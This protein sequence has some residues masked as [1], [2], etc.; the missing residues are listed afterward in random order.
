MKDQENSK[1]DFDKEFSMITN[2]PDDPR[3]SKR[4]GY[5]TA[6]PSE[7][8]IHF[9]KGK[10]NEKSSGQGA[11]C[12]KWPRDTVFIIPTS[13]KEIVFKANQLTSDNVDI[14]VRGMVVYKI[15]NPL[16]I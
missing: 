5:I 3:S 4:W 14:K 15:N 7:Y 1:I 11:S 16:K 2:S 6:L 10:L 8:L 12:F 9:K 13:M